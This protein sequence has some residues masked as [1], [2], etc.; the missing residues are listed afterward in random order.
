MFQSNFQTTVGVRIL[1]GL[2]AEAGPRTSHGAIRRVSGFGFSNFIGP[3]V[4]AVALLLCTQRVGV[5]LPFGP[6]VSMPYSSN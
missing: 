4:I 1:L 6:P 5:R 2:K 3:I